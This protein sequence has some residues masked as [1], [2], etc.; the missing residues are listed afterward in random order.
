MGGK[1]I[2]VGSNLKKCETFWKNYCFSGRIWPDRGNTALADMAGLG[3]I[4]LNN[5][6]SIHIHPYKMPLIAIWIMRVSNF[7]TIWPSRYTH[8][9]RKC[10][11][12]LSTGACGGKAF[13][14]PS[15]VKGAKHQ[16]LIP[17]FDFLGPKVN[18]FSLTVCS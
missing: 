5:I 15:H 18:F 3:S 14:R 17:L 16:I 4:G 6:G 10:W 8:E 9:K 1:Y 7:L 2:L 13:F 12:Q 11:S